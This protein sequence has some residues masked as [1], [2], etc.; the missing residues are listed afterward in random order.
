M[1]KKATT[2]PLGKQDLQSMKIKFDFFFITKDT[3]LRFTKKFHVINT[4]LHPKQWKKKCLNA[5]I[6]K[7]CSPIDLKILILSH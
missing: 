6:E 7:C 2:S 4:C 5:K 3:H 1:S